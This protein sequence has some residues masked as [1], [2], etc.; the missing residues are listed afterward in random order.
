MTRQPGAS[1]ACDSFPG[2]EEVVALA[3]TGTRFIV[4]G[5][6]HGTEQAPRLFG[7]LV[8][9]VSRR[10]PVNVFLELRAGS[11]TAVQAFI[12]SD[13]SE[14]ARQTFLAH[15]IWNPRF[16]DGRNSQAMFAL[17]DLLRRLR[18][19]GAPIQV[20]STQPD[21][22]TLAPQFYSELGRANGWAALG[23]AHPEGV[24]LILVGSAHAA[25]R[26]ND[27]LG[28][29]PATAHLRSADV[30]SIGP[31]EEGGAQWA[32]N[33]SDTGQPVVGISALPG[34]P[35]TRGIVML[36]SNASG[37]NATYAFG[38]PARP[39]PPQRNQGRNP[40]VSNRR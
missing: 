17:I 3:G 5:E 33:L 37:W 15:D 21:Y 6:K 20:F 22:P 29:L 7:T 38:E 24:N 25:L 1:Y 39:S 40:A 16:A 28:F 31:V 14:H 27:D 32:L 34:R 8:C 4:M 10:R 26:D 19:A 11:T 13:G 2:L 36:D 9:G 23:V 30:L 12:D 35:G 18:R